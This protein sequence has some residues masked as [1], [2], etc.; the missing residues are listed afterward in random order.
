VY[1]DIDPDNL[2]VAVSAV[3]E[4]GRSL[5][6]LI[7]VHA[8]GC[9]CDVEAVAQWCRTNGVFLIEDLATAQGA[10]SAGS[11]AG[12]WGDVSVMSFGQGKIID[13]GD[14]GAVLTDDRSLLAEIGDL[15]TSLPVASFED[16]AKVDDVNATHTA[17]Y[18][19][20]YGRD[21]NQHS[22]AFQQFAVGAR[23]G[24]IR[25]TR[26]DFV[27][28]VLRQ[29]GCLADNLAERERR[30]SYLTK[31]FHE[32]EDRQL[33][34]WQPREGSVYWRFNLFIRSH[35]DRML[36]TLLRRGYKVSSWYPSVDLFLENRATSGVRTPVSDE[37]GDTILN[38]WV[39]DEI[40][41]A[42]LGHICDAILALSRADPQN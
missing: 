29:L 36:R 17:L 16:L 24:L 7:A 15:E 12:A 31:R 1:L 38:L 13:V 35:R 4:S 20:H 27:E 25:R 28:P 6:A 23:N 41:C 26:D 42:Y 30:A 39:N 9:M 40:D 2:G 18:N 10:R 21:L 19:A 32:V 34:L 8:Y 11:P 5:A 22:A 37:I 3:R 14:G 33:S